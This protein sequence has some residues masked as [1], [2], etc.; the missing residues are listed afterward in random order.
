MGLFDFF[1]KA[2]KSNSSDLGEITYIHPIFGKME[3]NDGDWFVKDLKTP[4]FDRFFTLSLEGGEEG[5]S[6]EALEG[7]DF[8]L[9]NWDE[10]IE[11]Y[12]VFHAFYEM[13]EAYADGMK[14]DQ[15]DRSDFW[16]SVIP[17]HLYV[18][19]KDTMSFSVCF[20]WQDPSD[21][22]IVTAEIEN[23]ECVGC[24]VDG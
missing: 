15:V 11:S 3:D 20:T 13:H 22:H 19:S 10:I 5:P 14:L 16:K 7:Y 1:R 8:I 9:K 6:K 18:S 4:L 23:G 17:Q 24:P 21:G 2:Q 12:G